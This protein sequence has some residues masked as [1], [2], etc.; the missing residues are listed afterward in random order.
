M[1][2]RVSVVVGLGFGDEGKGS[3]TDYLVR[4]REAK[5]VVRF[6]GGS[7]AAHHV[8]TPEG[9]LHC[10]AQFG[11]GTFVTGA[12]TFLSRFMYIDPLALAREERVLREKGVMD[13]WRRLQVDESCVLVTPY[14]R[15]INRM[16]ET[17]RGAGRHGSC[18]AGV[19]E[20][21]RDAALLGE[22]TLRMGDLRSPGTAKAK[23]SFLQALKV[24][25]AE[26]L[27]EDYPEDNVLKY[28]LEELKRTSCD[29]LA[30]EYYR[31][32]NHS[33]L[34]LATSQDLEREIL[35]SGHAVFEG[36]QGALLDMERGFFPFVSV[37][38]TGAHNARELLKDII[39]DN[40]V[41]YIGVLRAY[42]TRHGAG[43][44]VSEDARLTEK[45]PD[46]HNVCNSWQGSMR[47]GWFD[48]VAFR[49]ALEVSGG[50][51]SLVVTNVDR[52][53]SLPEIKICS[54]Y[55][56][57]ELDGGDMKTICRMPFPEI[58]SLN[59]QQSLTDLLARC[60][61]Y[62]ENIS[63]GALLCAINDELPIS[64]V[65]YG[66]SALDKIPYNGDFTGQPQK[67]CVL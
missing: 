42:A 19:G 39:D 64:L 24:D 13:A 62:Y 17:S 44:F 34:T 57:P 40:D 66:P 51:D 4:S 53:L 36:A 46:R 61:P 7:Q 22:K 35:G 10:F 30:Q 28:Y 8:V 58:T 45:L 18:G 1:A 25:I 6:N 29:D 60:T 27:A 67:A 12:R 32:V 2:A 49:Y 5:L 26:Q 41:D 43:P 55:N 48:M 59:R 11:S 54:S 31:I 47:I 3:T 38:R 21:M 20:A 63:A 52:V 15:V 65:S 23:L 50:L 14:H 33:G 56:A 37:S 9:E 16:L